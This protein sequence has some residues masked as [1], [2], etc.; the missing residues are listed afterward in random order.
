M[1]P[2]IQLILMVP[3]QSGI[4]DVWTSEPNGQ[5]FADD[6][7]K[8]IIWNGNVW[9]SSKISV[10]C[11]QEGLIDHKA[12]LILVMAWHQIDD[13]P[14]PEPVMTKISD[15]TRSQSHKFGVKL[16]QLS[17]ERSPKFQLGFSKIIQMGVFCST[18]IQS[19][20]LFNK[21]GIAS[22]HIHFHWKCS[23]Y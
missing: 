1:E 18:Y 15:T 10:K 7:F 8:W 13:K 12:A 23:W 3:V 20:A 2:I 19:R 14:L 5:H 6:N 16:V 17:A 22:F 21:A 11:V 4:W 9:F